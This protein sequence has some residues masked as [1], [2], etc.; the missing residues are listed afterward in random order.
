VEDKIM[1]N[2]FHSLKE[3]NKSNALAFK[4]KRWTSFSDE[5]AKPSEQAVQRQLLRFQ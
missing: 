3:G 4:R 5:P 2:E 1:K